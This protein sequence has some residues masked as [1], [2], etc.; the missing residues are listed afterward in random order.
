MRL[1]EKK[2]VVPFLLI[3]T[4][5]F[6]W[7]FA[8]AV[9]DV[10]NKHFQ[11]T[12]HISLSQSTLIQAT[13]Y[14]GYFL[15]AI[16]SGIIINRYGYRRGVVGGLLLFAAGAFLFIPGA[17]LISFPIFLIALFLI[18][19]GLVV[20]ETSANPYAAELGDKSTAAS[21]LNF[22][23]SFNGF[24]CIL[25][26]VLVGG[27]LFGN[28]GAS[29]ALPYSLMGIVVL[30]VALIFSKVD[31]PELTSPTESRIENAEGSWKGAFSEI[32]QLLRINQFLLGLLALLFY[33]IS[34]IS[35][36]SL[37]INYVTSDGWMDKSTAS[38]LLSFG[39]LGL[40][41][42]ARIIGSWV[43]TKVKAVTVLMICGMMTVVGAVAVMM[44]I[45]F[46]SKAGLF[47][48]YAFEAI[49]FPTIFAI[50]IGYAKGMVKTASSLL[51]MTPIG[52]AVGTM[53][54]GAI[55]DNLSI[56]M[57]FVVPALGYACVFFY[58]VIIKSAHNKDV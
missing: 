30:I 27:F 47:V 7:G 48:C 13:T 16:P 57:A 49:M 19:C 10:L 17:S 11:D 31:L 3:I 44:N 8:R 4:L 14:L 56:S 38:V 40:F 23:Q 6:M 28:S 29:V 9:L 53:L 54:M 1:V 39:A 5:F 21:R 22:A 32:S 25:A 42:L 51:M 34:E 35:I 12:L 24:G 58:S 2:Y 18:G 37:F 41:M 55:S 45:G 52:G 33:E 50:T 26:P 20:L 36:N 15:M 46:V 43:M